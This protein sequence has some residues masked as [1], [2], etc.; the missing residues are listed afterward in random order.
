MVR[1]FNPLGHNWGPE[2]LDGYG[3]TYIVIAVT[4]SVFF[5]AL[6]IY[7]WLHRKHPIVRMRKINLA[8]LSILILHVY[9]FMALIVYPING[10]FPCNVEFWSMSLYLPIGIGLFQAQNQQLLIVSREQNMLVN[11]HE[12]WKELPGMRG[13]GLGSPRYWLYRFKIWW[14]TASQQGKYEGFVFAGIVVQVSS[15]KRKSCTA[16]K[17]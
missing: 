4:Y 9:L 3:I 11:R 14:K 10:A 1:F 15:L 13:G 12:M 6:C 5:Y 16:F 2:N 8:L 7:L 17:C